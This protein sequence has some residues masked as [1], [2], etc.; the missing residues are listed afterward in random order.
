MIII[1]K[2][3]APS[4]AVRQVADF[5][6]ERG[7]RAHISCGEERTIIGAVGDER[8]FHPHEL[9]SLPQVERAIRVLADWRIISRETQSEDSVIT[10]RGI[11]FG[12]GKVLDIAAGHTAPSGADALYTDPF[13]ISNNPYTEQETSSEKTQIRR[14]RETLDESHAAGRPVLVRVRDVRQIAPALQAG[15]DILYLGGELMGNRT[16]QNE[17]GR[18]N[19]PVVLCKDKHHLYNEWL[20]AAEHIALRGNHQIILGES[21][22]LSFE[23]DRQYR[24]DTDSVVRVRLLSHLP[25]LAN[26]TRLWHNG[27][28]QEILRRLAV[29]AGAN[30]IVSTIGTAG[31]QEKPRP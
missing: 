5:I 18:L 2:K 15:A 6:A 1:M 22:T 16:L 26:I 29:A 10:V 3:Q 21:G 14:M 30:A 9:E 24:F 19:T 31:Q 28:P 13:F 20:V 27:M 12:G 4:E 7:L 8:V 25:V 23:P 11:R 17:V